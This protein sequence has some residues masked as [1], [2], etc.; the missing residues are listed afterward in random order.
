MLK[1]YDRLKIEY[2][3]SLAKIEV[4]L[5]E[6]YEKKNKEVINPTTCN[7]Y[8]TWNYIIVN[9]IVQTCLKFIWENYKTDVIENSLSKNATC[10][11]FFSAFASSGEAARLKQQQ[12]E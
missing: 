5:K 2:D 12:N 8:I 3:T 7:T 1:E 10:L 9:I 6:C 11:L 4:R